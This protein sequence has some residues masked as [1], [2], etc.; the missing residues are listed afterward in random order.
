MLAHQRPGVDC[1]VEY[2]ED[3]EEWI[4]HLRISRAAF[5]DLKDEA[6]I[7]VADMDERPDQVVP[8]L[9]GG[10]EIGQAICQAADLPMA[11][12]GSQS[13]VSSIPGDRR[14]MTRED[15]GLT[16]P[17]RQFER[18]LLYLTPGFGSRILIVD[19][20]TDSGWT[21]ERCASWVRRSPMYSDFIRWVKTLVLW[22]KPT[23]SFTPDLFIDTVVAVP[24]PQEDG[25]LK[26]P[27]IDMPEEMRY[28]ATSL[29]GVRK[30]IA[31]RTA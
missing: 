11:V 17:K 28:A 27:W 7:R 16:L 18:D 15:T 10:F 20:L 14:K 25:K 9:K 1:I 3:R 8:I 12:F 21:L 31:D 24:V 5:D 4:P 2:H 23:S 26:I 6:V 22:H 29:D 13:Y 19:D 30:R